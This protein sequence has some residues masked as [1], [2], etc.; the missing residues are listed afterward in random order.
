M[1]APR[2]DAA[3]ALGERA[4]AGLMAAFAPF[5]ARPRIAVAVSGGADS[6]ALALLAHAWAARRGGR[7]LALTVDHGLRPGSAA[8]ARKVKR[9]LAARGIDHRILVWRGAKPGTNLQAAARA[10]RYRLLGE[11]CRRLGVLHLLL[12]HHREDQ[13]ETLLL[14]LARGSGVEGLAAMAPVAERAELRLLRPLLGVPREQLKATLAKAAAGWVEDPSNRDPRHARVRLRALMPAL[15]AEGMTAPRL[16][17]T[18]ARLGRARQA[19]EAEVAHLLG[20][21]ATVDPAGHVLLAAAPLAAAEAEVG[22][23]ALARVLQSVGGSAHPPRLERLERLYREIAAAGLPA[24]RTLGGCRILRA[25]ARH[26]RDLLLVCREWRRTEA[27]AL[28]A[29]ERAVW[30]G[31]FRLRLG[32][33]GAP[34]AGLSVGALGEAG[35]SFL[36]RAMPALGHTP[37]PAAV[38]PA[39]PALFGLEGVIA[40]PHLS[41]GRG[42]DETASVSVRTL[43]FA[44]ARALAS[45]ASSVA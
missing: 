22:L 2:Q 12:A 23:R 30:D 36:L 7:A 20:A 32:R 45:G 5:E 15:A 26:G 38:R 43:I 1:G 21:S 3:G 33:G 9:L 19:L 14:R 6:M 4:F 34:R 13:A 18:A 10:A 28:R 35:W 17:A 31:R 29:G 37:L 8:E 25:P 40:V 41:Y 24:P 16:A 44:P 39:L 42:R 27:L 11:C